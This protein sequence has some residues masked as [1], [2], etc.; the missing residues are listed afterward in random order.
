MGVS[1]SFQQWLLQSISW[2]ASRYQQNEWCDSYCAPEVLQLGLA[3]WMPAMNKPC[4][5]VNN[6]PAIKHKQ[7][8]YSRAAPS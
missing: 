7:L 5:W 6:E 3:Q 8:R 1:L 4:C 2:T